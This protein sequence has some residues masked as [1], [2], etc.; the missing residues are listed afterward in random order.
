MTKVAG[1]ITINA[2]TL[3]IQKFYRRFNS[4]NQVLALWKEKEEASRKNGALISLAPPTFIKSLIE[5]KSNI[6]SFKSNS[7]MKKSEERDKKVDNMLDN[8]NETLRQGEELNR[9]FDEMLAARLNQ[10]A[11]M[12]SSIEESPVKSS[13]VTRQDTQTTSTLSSDELFINN[14]GQ[15]IQIYN[16]YEYCREANTPWK[17]MTFLLIFCYFYHLIF[18]FFNFFS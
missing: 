8:F 10:R 1:F 5:K 2:A 7:L 12:M 13:S 14:F 3:V 17:G 18:P 6:V 9:L 11:S 16:S 4:I 15:E